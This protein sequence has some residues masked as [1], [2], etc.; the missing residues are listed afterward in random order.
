[1][2]WCFLRASQQLH[3]CLLVCFLMILEQTGRFFEKRNQSGTSKK[4]SQKVKRSQEPVKTPPRSHEEFHTQH[5]FLFYFLSYEA[6][7]HY[8]SA[9]SRALGMIF[10]CGADKQQKK[11][12]E[13]KG[14]HL[15]AGVLHGCCS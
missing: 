9:S 15:Q 5:I 14:P 11:G 4:S 7:L 12:K 1:M 10:E 8:A 2:P 13:R 3:L 6:K